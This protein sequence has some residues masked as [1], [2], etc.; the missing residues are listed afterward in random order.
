MVG[1]V[2]AEYVIGKKR[3]CV[4]WLHMGE[5]CYNTTNH[6]STSMSPF[7]AL[8]GYDPLSFADMI[9][10]DCRAPGAKDW[11]QGSQDISRA[12]KDNLHSSAKLV[13]DLCR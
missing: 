5:Y 13:Q 7:C 6:M 4:K 2:F 8:Y 1:G 12:L 10:G 3:A 9:F 11:I